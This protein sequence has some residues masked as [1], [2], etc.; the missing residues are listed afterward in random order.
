MEDCLDAVD[1]AALKLLAEVQAQQNEYAGEDDD[2]LS[3]FDR[4]ALQ[5]L[6]E[7]QEDLADCDEGGSDTGLADD[8]EA[9]DGEA[10][11]DD[12]ALAADGT[13]VHGRTNSATV[14]AYK[15]EF[16]AWCL[17]DADDVSNAGNLVSCRDATYVQ[18]L[19]D[20]RLNR[21]YR[22]R[23]ANGA[24]PISRSSMDNRLD[25]IRQCRTWGFTAKQACMY[26]GRRAKK[27]LQHLVDA[28][29]SCLSVDWHLPFGEWFWPIDANWM[30]SPDEL[31]GWKS[32]LCKI[33]S[34]RLTSLMS[35]DVDGLIM[36]QLTNPQPTGR[37]ISRQDIISAWNK[38]RGIC[39][40]GRHMWIGIDPSID[41][42]HDDVCQIPG[43]SGMRSHLATIQRKTDLYPGV[44]HLAY[45]MEDT[46]IC[47]ACNVFHNAVRRQNPCRVPVQQ[48][49]CEECA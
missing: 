12:G 1:R 23:T 16:R 46:M 21:W 20:K 30:E 10:E 6:H 9:E 8:G 31:H 2:Q 14:A 45:N 5:L 32:S 36:G 34:K 35:Q 3:E 37:Y 39:N 29:Q 19:G 28:D 40:C 47:H 44:M 17:S 18:H 48:Q 25:V 43:C 15:A 33:L 42:E 38:S 49:Q 22:S 4:D 26:G 41:A 11:E 7:L 27:R 24:P 13:D